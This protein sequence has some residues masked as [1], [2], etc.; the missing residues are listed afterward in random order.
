M[1]I[2]KAR[3]EEEI[4]AAMMIDAQWQNAAAKSQA[5]YDEGEPAPVKSRQKYRAA[6]GYNAP[7]DRRERRNA[8]KRE[9][10]KK[11]KMILQQK[12]TADAS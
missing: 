1:P 9:A 5:A 8:Q 6:W 4:R 7:T 2:S 12:E 11:A 3:T 10:R